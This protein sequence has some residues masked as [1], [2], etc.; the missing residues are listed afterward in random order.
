[1][2]VIEAFKKDKPALSFEFFPPKTP[3]QE[4]HLFATLHTLKTFQPD[5]VSVTYGAMGKTRE[6]T[7]TWV[8]KIKD[9]FQ[10][11]PVA[12]LTCI[13]ATRPDIAEQLN[14]LGKIGIDNI[15]ALR[16]DPPAG[17]EIFVAS[18][19]GFHFAKELIAFIKRLQP[20]FCLGAACF[21]ENPAS[22]PYLKEKVVA[23]AEYAISQLFFDN[24]FYFAFNEKCQKTGINVP[25]IP[26]LMPITS[27][28][29]IKKMTSVCCATI[30]AKLL[31]QLEKHENDPSAIEKIGAEHTTAQAQGLLKAGAPGLHFFVMN[32]AEPIS[33][34]LH[35]LNVTGPNT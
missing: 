22:I 9:E 6:K 29:Q 25:I 18:P 2:K 1:M 7:F 20:Q 31:A 28:K 4:E 27:L 35:N 34:I 8:K 33:T 30:P 24:D 12:H 11:E 19:D 32:Q 26:G 3:E 23:G 14:L 5:F 16:G 15:L 10:L 17:Q 13:A 21:P